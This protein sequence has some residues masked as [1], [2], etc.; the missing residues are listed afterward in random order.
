MST[1]KEQLKKIF[2]TSTE[3]SEAACDLMLQALG[4]AIKIKQGPIL[5]AL[6]DTEGSPATI[7]G[8][9]LFVY[10]QYY[11]CA[12]VYREDKSTVTR[13]LSDCD[14]AY[15]VAAAAFGAYFQAPFPDCSIPSPFLYLLSSNAVRIHRLARGLQ[16][17]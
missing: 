15:L 11:F 14:L 6:M 5:W 10:L 9:K 17:V 2:E 7:S 3:L 16:Q 8:L 4:G 13:P 12:T 1:P